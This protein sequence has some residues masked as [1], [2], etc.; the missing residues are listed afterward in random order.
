MLSSP[1]GQTSL[2]TPIRSNIVLVYQAVALISNFALSLFLGQLRVF[3]CFRT[4]F[5]EFASKHAKD[6]RFKAI[7]KMKDREA[8]FIEFM[9]SL[10][11]KEKED[12]KNRG[13]KV[14]T[15]KKP[16]AH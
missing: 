8:I 9:T 16:M 1:P 2:Q 4:T 5:S 10:K 3:V 13:E 15:E 6:Q 11:K 7:E 14:S 12:S